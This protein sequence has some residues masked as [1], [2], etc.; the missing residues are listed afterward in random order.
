MQFRVHHIPATMIGINIFGISPL[1]PANTR[2]VASRETDEPVAT[3]DFLNALSRS[4]PG[5]AIRL[6]RPYIK[7]PISSIVQNNS[8]VFLEGYVHGIRSDEVLNTLASWINEKGF[9]AKEIQKS[10]RGWSGDFAITII[11]NNQCW[12]FADYMGRLSVYWHYDDGLFFAGRSLQQ[13]FTVYQRAADRIGVAQAAWCGYP[14]ATNTFYKGVKRLK[15]NCVL[16]YHLASHHFEFIE[17]EQMNFDEQY[18]QDSKQAASE[19]SELFLESCRKIAH[20]VD[21]PINMSLSG[22]QDSRLVAWGFS[23]TNA[24]VHA[25]SFR[26]PEAEKDVL[27]AKKISDICKIPLDVFDLQPNEHAEQLLLDFKQGMSYVGMAFIIDFYEQLQAFFP[28]G[29]LYVTGDGSDSTLRFLGEPDMD[30]RMDELVERQVNRY[31][32]LPPS[33]VAIMTGVSPEELKQSIYKLLMSYPAQVPNNKSYHYYIFERGPQYFFEGEDRSKC[34]FW[35]TN[36]FFDLELFNR[37]R[38]IPQSYKKSYKFFRQ[39]M[40]ALHYPLSEVPDANGYPIN[41]WQYRARRYVQENYRSANPALKNMLHAINS[42]KLNKDRTVIN[43]LQ[44]DL[45]ALINND[46]RLAWMNGD[47]VKK[48]LAK[49]DEKQTQFVRNILKALTLND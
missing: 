40:H 29:S 24:K 32:I 3:K 35:A 6:S 14:I 4:H 33:D 31:M 30:V 1:K 21:V 13:L 27:I 43:S 25:T 20:S 26:S 41:S 28:E 49:A 46:E 16:V 7:Y 12:V 19:L 2:H 45:P 38:I 42:K 44:H 48:V 5:F 17:G 47:G 37:G 18:E 23:Q 34:F 9:T 8:L 36:P 11:T 15:G 10:I 22:G 39:F